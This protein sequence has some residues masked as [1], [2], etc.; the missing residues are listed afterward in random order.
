VFL[1]EHNGPS[2]PLF[3]V[4]PLVLHPFERFRTGR[5]SPCRTNHSGPRWV[6]S[7]FCVPA[8]T[9]DAFCTQFTNMHSI[10][11]LHLKREANYA[12]G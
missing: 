2:C 11:S 5:H 6:S 3:L 12:A 7:S 10:S 1:Q 4:W 8:G 9:L